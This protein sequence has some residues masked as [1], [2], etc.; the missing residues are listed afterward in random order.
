MPSMTVN[1]PDFTVNCT[2][3]QQSYNI[4]WTLP[5]IQANAT[6]TSQTLQIMC[7]DPPKGNRTI[8]VNSTSMVTGTITTIQLGTTLVNSATLKYKANK[9]AT[10]TMTVSNLVYT[11]EYEVARPII[12][13]LSSDKD[14][15]GVSDRCTIA[16]QS[17]VNLQQW[18]ARATTNTIDDGHG[19]GA[20][21]ESGNSLPA[22]TTA[23]VYVDTSELSSGDLTYRIDIYGQDEY[24]VWSDG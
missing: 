4:A 7:S 2:T 9:N 21:V 18:E 24:G 20:L 22:G 15:I 3:S 5:D 23:Y 1:I 11:V 6:I 16:F 19:V 13:I 14:K 17:N 8:Y 12:T 10:G